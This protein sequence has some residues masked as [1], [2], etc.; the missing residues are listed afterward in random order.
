MSKP[1]LPYG[2]YRERDEEEDY[3]DDADDVE[4]DVE[5]DPDDYEEEAVEETTSVQWKGTH[6]RF[7]DDPDV[8]KESVTK[9]AAVPTDE[10]GMMMKNM[11]IASE[12]ADAMIENSDVPFAADD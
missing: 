7:E 4:E 10:L 5:I 6:I 11:D 12:P 2:D 3:E 9:A 8:T 1:N